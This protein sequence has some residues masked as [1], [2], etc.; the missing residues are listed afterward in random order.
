MLVF[1]SLLYQHKNKKVGIWSFHKE[2]FGLKK[3]IPP[4]LKIKIQHLYR[5]R[6]RGGTRR[7]GWGDDSNGGCSTVP[8]AVWLRRWCRSAFEERTVGSETGVFFLT[9]IY[10]NVLGAK[11]LN[12]F[13]F[14]E[15]RVLLEFY[16]WEEGTTD[17]F[18]FS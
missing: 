6:P 14:V 7:R 4:D 8:V 5:G 9:L 18:W 2:A 11:R 13:R 16:V 3:W 17:G 10:I 1:C 15:G 12:M